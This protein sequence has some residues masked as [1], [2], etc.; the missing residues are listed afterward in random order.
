MMDDS[1]TTVSSPILLPPE[2][3]RD[4]ISCRYAALTNLPAEQLLTTEE[5]AKCCRC[6]SRTIQRWVRN[7]QLPAPSTLGNKSIWFVG[8]IREW[9]AE[10]SLE[11]EKRLTKEVRKLHNYEFRA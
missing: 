9:I 3:P 6:S 10:K 7:L 1:P 8:R 4:R 2:L 5:L 11:A